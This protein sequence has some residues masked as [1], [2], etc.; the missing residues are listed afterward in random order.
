MNV[1]Q[2][3]NSYHEEICDNLDIREYFFKEDKFV[4]SAFSLSNAGI[5]V[6]EKGL[7]L[8]TT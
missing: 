3:D 7:R 4:L 2:S 1:D 8:Q 6:L 5:L